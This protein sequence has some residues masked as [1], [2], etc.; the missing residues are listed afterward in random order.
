MNYGESMIKKYL[1]KIKC[2]I[3][4]LFKKYKR[5][6]NSV[7]KI[8]IIFN[9]SGWIIQKFASMLCDNLCKLGI[10][11]TISS[12]Y[13]KNADINHYFFPNHAP[14]SNKHVTFMITHVDLLDKVELI[15]KQTENGAVGICM[16]LETRNKLISYGIKPDR[17]CYI[18]PAQDEQILPRK[19]RLGFTNRVYDD[20]R[21]RESMLVDVCKKIDNRI[22][23]FCIMGS[24]WEPI[25]ESI[26]ELGFEVEYYPDFDKKIYNEL[27][28]N[29]DY[30]CYFGFDEGSMGFLDALAAGVGTIVTPQ[31]YHLDMGVDI[32]YPVSTIDDIINALH[33]IE[34]N[35][36]K[37]IDFSKKFTWEAYARKHI[38]IW[39][40]MLDREDLSDILKTRGWYTDGIYSLLLK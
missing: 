36:I 29:L 33:E 14:V 16:S 27:I 38:E 18:N 34:T 26:K 35:R 40:Y 21:K 39:N 31:G 8:N 15:K 32:T 30:Y 24:G 25:I 4:D 7:M 20:S 11:A 9:E 28:T 13:D 23:K 22:F 1:Y 3:I 12:Q 19:I 2:R 10:D 5:R 37:A 17:L 6:N